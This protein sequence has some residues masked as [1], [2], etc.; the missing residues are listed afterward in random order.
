[1]VRSK[2]FEIWKI[3]QKNFFFRQIVS[4]PFK[5]RG[6]MQC[7]NWLCDFSPISLPYFSPISLPY[8]PI[9]CKLDNLKS[10]LPLCEITTFTWSLSALG[11]VVNYDK[12]KNLF[13]LV[14]YKFSQGGGSSSN[15][16]TLI[17]KKIL[18]EEILM[19]NLLLFQNRKL[20]QAI[21][22]FFGKLI[23]F[24]KF[25]KDFGE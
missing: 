14:V 16:F 8:F 1:V 7:Q 17:G 12:W 2:K 20:K 25:S 3:L 9:L 18:G 11:E 6:W 5:S 19:L 23:K 22:Q 21:L 4:L 10:Q 13:F 15:R 24:N